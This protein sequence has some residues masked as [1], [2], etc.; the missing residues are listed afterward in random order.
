MR[1]V[2]KA[3][4]II[5]IVAIIGLSMAACDDG[6]SSGGPPGSNPGSNPGSGSGLVG[7]WYA[8]Q[9]MA[10]AGDTPLIEFTSNGKLI[11]AGMDFGATYTATSNTFSVYLRGEFMLKY[12]YSISGTVL[13]CNCPEEPNANM[14][15][16]WYKP[17]R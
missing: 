12:N 10:D 7:K 13:T 11:Q 16:T 6:G 17:R 3:F 1:N 5:A 14:V 8:S 9:G 15:G 2:L 4:G